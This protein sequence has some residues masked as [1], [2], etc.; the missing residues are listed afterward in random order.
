MK[1]EAIGLIRSPFTHPAGMPI[2]PVGAKGIKGEI[3]IFPEF[4][5]GLLDLEGFSHLIL[6]YHFHEV[7]QMKLRLKPF[8]ED[9]EHGIFATRA[10]T[11]P[12][13]IGLSVVSLIAIEGDILKIKDVDILDQT[14]LLDIKPYVPEFDHPRAVRTGWLEKRQEKAK[15]HRADARFI[16]AKDDQNG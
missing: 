11:R 10:P 8:L 5:P 15:E 9:R 3:E 4:L 2:Q 14:P 16:Q 7:R 13:P 12:N 1:F 6:L